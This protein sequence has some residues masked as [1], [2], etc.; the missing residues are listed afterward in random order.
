MQCED[1]SGHS[2]P[3]MGSSDG[4]GTRPLDGRPVAGSDRLLLGV[5]EH[6]H[7]V[8]VEETIAMVSPSCCWRPQKQ[9]LLS[10]PRESVSVQVGAIPDRSSSLPLSALRQR[11]SAPVPSQSPRRCRAEVDRQPTKLLGTR[12][13]AAAAA[14]VGVAA[15]AEAA[16]S[17][18]LV[19]LPCE[20]M[21]EHARV[22]QAPRRR[23]CGWRRA[24]G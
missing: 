18:L 4:I 2:V 16:R 20:P 17:T 3:Q 12:T 23:R 24:A 11:R 8:P 6:L 10:D 22:T 5:A 15:E 13:A 21:R 14:V 9:H 19:P 1:R 7:W